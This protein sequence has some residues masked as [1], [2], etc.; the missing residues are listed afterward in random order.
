MTLGESEPRRFGRLKQV[1]DKADG[2]LGKAD[3][4]LRTF[5]R[6]H[7]EADLRVFVSYRRMAGPGQAHRLA[8]DL[9]AQLGED[10]VFLDEQS[11]P[12]GAPFDD[13][14]NERV[15]R[16]DVLLAVIG[17]GWLEAE[18]PAPASASEHRERRLDNPGDYVR[19]EIE[20]ALARR[21]PVIPVTTP[22]ATLPDGDALPKSLRPLLDRAALRVEI[23]RDDVWVV[24]VDSLARWLLAIAEEKRT[25]D[26]EKHEA[27]VDRAKLERDAEKARQRLV[28]SQTVAAAAEHTR[29]TL[30]QQVPAAQGDLDRCRREAGPSRLGPGV[31]VFISNLGQDSVEAGKL[32]HDLKE[33]LAPD[34]VFTSEPVPERAQAATVIKERIARCDALLA[35]IG[36]GWLD[37]LDGENSLDHPADPV[38]LE[39]EEALTRGVPIVPVLIRRA[40]LP[41]RDALP[42]RLKPLLSHH[43][44][45]LP[46]QFW[47]AAVERLVARFEKIEA[48]IQQ[49]ERAV[50]SAAERHRELA[51]DLQKAAD[52]QAESQAAFAAAKLKVAELEEHVRQAQ[53]REE[54]LSVEPG[55]RNR[56]FLDG[57]PAP[58]TVVLD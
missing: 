34:R 30:E 20:A 24:A 25:I 8:T 26:K 56:A 43:A 51:L 39:I 58:R 17:P 44:M 47:D 21:V 54:R 12:E 38:A 50:T 23:P 40:A 6:A 31:R 14:I 36:P 13:V 48:E 49:R 2:L 41:E 52:K 3:Q 33:R 35:I 45:P 32:E 5:V 1:F 57:P 10:R 18:G 22:G 27:A 19:R 9:E 55:D 37:A 4:R 28:E 53:A 16:C 7:I 11:I 46:E 29:A 15:G 42:E